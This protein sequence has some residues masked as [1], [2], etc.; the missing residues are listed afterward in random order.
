MSGIEAY[1]GLVH[2]AKE[3]EMQATD[4]PPPSPAVFFVEL[5]FVG[6]R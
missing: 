5:F 4:P 1:I 2:I 3:S 6:S